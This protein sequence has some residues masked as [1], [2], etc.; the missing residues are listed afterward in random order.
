MLKLPR[1]L[2]R[3]SFVSM[4][5]IGLAGA[6]GYA[7]CSSDDPKPP[8]TPTPDASPTDGP[9]GTDSTVKP[10]D[11]GGDTAPACTDPVFDCAANAGNTG[12]D[13]AGANGTDAGAAG[14]VAISL[15]CTG[16]Y[17]CWT[18]KTVAAEN[19]L[20][21]P[22]FVLYSDGADKSRWLQLPPGSTIDTGGGDAGTV[23]EWNLPVGTKVFKEFKLGG[24][25][26]ETRQIWKASATET[27]YSVWRWKDDE[28]DAI[29][30]YAGGLVPNP[31]RPGKN[32]EIPKT[33]QCP[34]CHNGHKDHFL[35]IDAWSLGA[36]A[37][38]V[39]LDMLKT[40]GHLPSWTYPT[41]IAQPQDSTGKF[42]KAAGFYYANCGFCHKPGMPAG[43]A[44]GLFFHLP[45]AEA[46]PVDGGGLPDGGAGI[47]GEQTPVYVTAVNVNKTG[48][49]P[50]GV[51]KRIQ[52]GDADASA[53]YIRDETRDPDGGIAPS[54]MP[55]LLVRTTDDTQLEA[56]RQ[57][58]NSIP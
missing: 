17:S 36:G 39:T 18:T 23:D 15:K 54:Q 4:A 16:L 57:W 29:L 11:S 44:T 37:T 38:G 52:P 41:S 45:V 30:T 58:I 1:N 33:T 34:T 49:F 40:E 2:R 14:Q 25:H 7:G 46:L 21:T 6:F 51:P 35:S 5:A 48:G 22:A 28:S 26:V 8:A 20:Y 12:V 24:K 32:Y 47:V 50:A 53:V 10:L 43:N 55:P 42:D 27:I 56:T 3:A 19:R 13:D 31:D 9:S